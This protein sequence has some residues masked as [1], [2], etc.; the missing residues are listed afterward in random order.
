MRAAARRAGSGTMAIGL[1]DAHEAVHTRLC[2]F[3][4]L[5]QHHTGERTDYRARANKKHATSSND[6]RRGSDDRGSAI[7]QRMI[8]L[9]FAPYAIRFK[10]ESESRAQASR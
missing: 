9:F 6:H 4:L 7:L 10:I 2:N 5:R 1:M 3:Q 8:A